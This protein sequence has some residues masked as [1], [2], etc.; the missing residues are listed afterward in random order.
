VTERSPNSLRGEELA[1]AQSSMLQLKK[2]IKGHRKSVAGE[3]IVL[4][5]GFVAVFIQLCCFM[6]VHR[7]L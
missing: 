5:L 4:D 6:K 2:T 3:E 7:I 1:T